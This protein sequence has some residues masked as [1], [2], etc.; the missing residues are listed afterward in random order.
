M[1]AAFDLPPIRQGSDA[2]EDLVARRSM[3][4]ES[5]N[6]FP[7]VDDLMIVEETISGV[8]VIRVTSTDKRRGTVLHLHGGGFRLGTPDIYVGFASYLAAAA[9][10]E[11]ILPA[12]RLAPENPFP[13]GLSDVLAVVDGLTQLERDAL[14]ISG[15]SAGGGLATSLMHVV[16]SRGMRPR[17][18]MI[19]SPWLDLR[20]VHGSYDENAASDPLFSKAS[21]QQA[22][23][24]YLQGHAAD[25]PLASPLLGAVSDFPST[26]LSVSEHEVLRDDSLALADA[27]RTAGRDVE[28]VRVPHMQHV[29]PTRDPEMVGS[30]ETLAATKRFLARILN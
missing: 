12:Y 3:V 1:S 9:Q 14:V 8:R 6:R 29:A 22:A 24:Q 27:L 23:T 10:V 7:P 13:A 11:V 28:V 15:D 19:H 5:V 20:V 26:L 18:L 25:D 4:A 21:A 2:P 16:L 30:A 17:G